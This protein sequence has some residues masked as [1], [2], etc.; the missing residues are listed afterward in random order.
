MPEVSKNVVLDWQDVFDAV[1]DPILVLD[2]QLRVVKAN[3]AAR[4]LVGR[5]RIVGEYCWDIYGCG[6]A[7]LEHCP[8]FR[9]LETGRSSR[10]ETDSYQLAEGWFDVRTYPL[11]NGGDR[12]NLAVHIVHDITERK[13]AEGYPETGPGTIRIGL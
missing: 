3:L 6:D 10:L 4:Q 8:V 5:E 1:G 13:R 11:P 7:P 12:V 2:R 9:T